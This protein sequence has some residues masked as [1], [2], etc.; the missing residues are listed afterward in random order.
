M[1]EPTC[2]PRDNWHAGISFL[3]VYWRN[4]TLATIT[5]VTQTDVWFSCHHIGFYYFGTGRWRDTEIDGRSVL[6]T[7]LNRLEWWGG[8]G[9]CHSSPVADFHGLF[10]TWQVSSRTVAMPTGEEGHYVRR[11][12]TWKPLIF[13]VDQWPRLKALSSLQASRKWRKQGR[14]MC[15]DVSGGC[16]SQLISR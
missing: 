2:V 14:P 6:R 13:P 1:D 3:C 12:N 8:N 4:G 11:R 7:A 9:G 16:S 5:R 10:Q 15:T